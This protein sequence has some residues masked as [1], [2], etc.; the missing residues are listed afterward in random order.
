MRKFYLLT[1]TVYLKLKIVA[2]TLPEADRYVRIAS[3]TEAEDQALIE[4]LRRII[5]RSQTE[6]SKSP[7]QS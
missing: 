3:R 2:K 5:V 7:S 1:C 4:A 6:K